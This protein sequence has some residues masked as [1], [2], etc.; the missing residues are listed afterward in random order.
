MIYKVGSNV[1]EMPS[2]KILWAVSLQ[3]NNGCTTFKACRE[4]TSKDLSTERSNWSCYTQNPNIHSSLLHP[5]TIKPKTEEEQSKRGNVFVD[6]CYFLF[7]PVFWRGLECLLF[8]QLHLL[9]CMGTLEFKA[10]HTAQGLQHWLPLLPQ[11]LHAYVTGDIALKF[12][13]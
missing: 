4:R 11:N 6:L 2:S 3:R 10:T 9:L 13:S 12:Y 5:F 1:P 7:V 8:E